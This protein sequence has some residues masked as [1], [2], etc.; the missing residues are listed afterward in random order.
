MN[1]YELKKKIVPKLLPIRVKGN[2]QEHGQHAKS[3]KGR[4]IDP[5]L[6]LKCSSVACNTCILAC[7]NTHSACLR[8]TFGG[9]G[10]KRSSWGRKRNSSDRRS[11][12]YSAPPTKFRWMP[13]RHIWLPEAVVNESNYTWDV[14][15]PGCCCCWVVICRRKT[16]LIVDVW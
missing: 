14:D 5:S 10:E 9:F 16:G 4:L 8:T 11:F 7:D 6:H 1:Y 2:E 15:S 12:S 13:V 3:Y